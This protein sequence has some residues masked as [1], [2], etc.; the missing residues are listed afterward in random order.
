ML[1]YPNLITFEGG[2]GS[3]KSTQITLLKQA[4]EAKYPNILVTK[5]PG[6][7]ELGSK[8]RSLLLDPDLKIDRTTELLLYLADR[9]QLIE[10]IILPALNQG[11]LVFCDRFS[12]STYAYQIKARKGNR[13]L[14]DQLQKALGPTVLPGLTFWLDISP[15]IGLARARKRGGLDK[16][17]QEQLDFH[18]AVRE[19]YVELYKTP[20]FKKKQKV[21]RIDANTSI[22]NVHTQILEHALIFLKTYESQT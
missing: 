12:D 21:Q 4:L 6:G 11:N 5:A 13:K 19:G 16:M 7:S 18:F 15:Q 20:F 9:Q 8:L 10:E 3:G 22:E 1:S 2:E 17:E 14:F